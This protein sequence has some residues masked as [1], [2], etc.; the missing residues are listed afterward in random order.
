MKTD[1]AEENNYCKE[2]AIVMATLKDIKV[3]EDEGLQE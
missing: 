1:T 2:E 3:V